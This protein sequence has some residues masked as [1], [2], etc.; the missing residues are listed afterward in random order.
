MVP[1]LYEVQAATVRV[2]MM[3]RLLKFTDNTGLSSWQYVI[4]AA[5]EGYGELCEKA[6]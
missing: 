3:T 4:S 1:W 6:R 2:E 5:R